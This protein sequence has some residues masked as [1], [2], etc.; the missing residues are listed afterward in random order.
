MIRLRTIYI[1]NLMDSCNKMCFEITFLQCTCLSQFHFTKSITFCLHTK[2]LSLFRN[3]YHHHCLHF[4]SFFT[5]SDLIFSSREESYW[6]VMEPKEKQTWMLWWLSLNNRWSS[7]NEVSRL[8]RVTFCNITT[9]TIEIFII[10]LLMYIFW[11]K[12]L[13]QIDEL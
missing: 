4:G 12:G 3:C 5:L 10:T 13:V 9:A 6:G 11:W 7:S 8:V 1:I 2:L